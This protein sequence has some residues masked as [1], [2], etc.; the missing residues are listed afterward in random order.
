MVD[1]HVEQASARSTSDVG[2]IE[3]NAVR[4]VYRLGDMRA[5]GRALH[6]ANARLV[7]VAW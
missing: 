6:T 1:H 2:D 7:R 4:D 5:V 3:V